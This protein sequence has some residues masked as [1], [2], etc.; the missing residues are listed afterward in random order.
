MKKIALIAWCAILL[1][2]CSQEDI[3]KA[4]EAEKAQTSTINTQVPVTEEILE[5]EVTDTEFGTQ[6]NTTLETNET[7]EMAKK[8][9]YQTT[10]LQDGDLVATIKTTNGTMKVKLFADEVPSTV[11]N[12]AALA[13]D[14]YYDWIIFHRI[15]SGFM[16]QGWDPTGTG[17]WWESIYWEKFNDEFSDKLTNI[18]YSLS[19]ANSG[20]N[21]NGSQ[22]FINQADNNFLDNKHSVFGQ[23]IEG[24]DNVEKIAKVKTSGQDKPVK[25]VKII[26]IAI[27]KYNNSKL[28]DITL[29][30]EE[31]ISK[32]N[33]SLKAWEEAKKVEAEAKKDKAIID[34]DTVSVHYT[35]TVDGEKLDSS[36]DRGTPFDF[37]IWAQQV[38]VGWEKW[39]IGHKIWDKFELEVEPKDGYGVYDETKV[40]IVPKEQLADFEKNGIEL[41][42]GNKLPTQF[43]EFEIKAVTDTEVTLN[44]NHALADKTLNF[45]IEVIDI[46]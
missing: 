41:K 15:I 33:D 26:S 19:M 20:T 36:V 42:V 43:W 32:Y 28:E 17:M 40:E 7:E 8:E 9:T 38:I 22:F 37:T 16:I 2:S 27:Q 35:L 11:N 25:D 18:K 1:W 3:N 39:L 30:K 13:Q 10:P 12:F 31:L 6:Q 24:M 5:T 14:K 45:D 46:K 21:T 29:D 34:W 23:V 44:V 4:K